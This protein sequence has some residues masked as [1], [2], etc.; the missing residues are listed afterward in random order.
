[1]LD[2][3]IKRIIMKFRRIFSFCIYFDS[4]KA[5]GKYPR[6]IKVF[7]LQR[8]YEQSLTKTARFPA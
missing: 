6:L 5:V 1:M 8:T 3:V 4:L 2:Q 7:N